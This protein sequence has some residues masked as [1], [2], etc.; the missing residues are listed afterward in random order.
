MS[1][2]TLFA[3]LHALL[4]VV[5]KAYAAVHTPKGMR[6]A[7]ESAMGSRSPGLALKEAA[8]AR[9]FKA[10]MEV[11]LTMHKTYVICTPL[12]R[13]VGVMG[14]LSEHFIEFFKHE[15]LM[16]MWFFC[17]LFHVCTVRNSHAISR[18]LFCWLE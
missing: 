3:H 12:V 8:V 17:F 4:F 16:P 7:C 6:L 9:S 2:P 11:V 1:R 18:S 5:D 14:T 10:C 13:L 15:T